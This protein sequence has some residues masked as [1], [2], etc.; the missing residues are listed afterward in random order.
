MRYTIRYIPLSRIKPGSITN[1]LTQRM[2]ELRRTAQDCMHMLIVRKSRREGGYVVVSGHSHLDYLKKH[3]KKSAVAC[4][5]DESKLSAKLSS[6]VYH[7]RKPR[8]PKYVPSIKPERLI[9]SSGAI[10]TRYLRQDPRFK[11]LSRSQQMKVLRMGLNYKKTT[12][13][14]MKA[15]VDEFLK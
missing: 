3:T 5:V 7:F 2:K 11:S 10:I 8:L 9:G 1:K 6:F 13:L 14:S 12:I 15:Q 4:L